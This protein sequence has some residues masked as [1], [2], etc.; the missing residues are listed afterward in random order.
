M[1]ICGARSAVVA[2]IF[3]IKIVLF[4]RGERQ[5]GGLAQNGLLWRARAQL[6]AGNY[7]PSKCLL[8]GE[9]DLNSTFCTTN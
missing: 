1:F 8:V 4:R 3:P 2:A 5:L 7:A 9:C 6:T